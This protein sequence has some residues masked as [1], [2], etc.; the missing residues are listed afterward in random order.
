M[1]FFIGFVVD[2][3]FRDEEFWKTK[4]EPQVTNFFFD[5]LVPEMIDSRF[6]RGLPI[7]SGFPEPWLFRV[8]FVILFVYT[9]FNNNTYININIRYIP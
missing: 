3:I 4:I 6:V 7:R 5:S 2:K 1:Y 9:N 8:Y